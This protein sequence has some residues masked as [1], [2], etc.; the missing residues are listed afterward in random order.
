MARPAP[1]PRAD[2]RRRAARAVQ[3]QARH[4]CIGIP[5][6]SAEARKVQAGQ[7][8]HRAHPGRQRPLRA[9]RANVRIGDASHQGP[10]R[11]CPLN[12][13]AARASGADRRRDAGRRVRAAHERRHRR[14]RRRHPPLL[15]RV[16]ERALAPADPPR[17][18]RLALRDRRLR[19]RAG[20]RQR[21]AVGAEA[22]GARARD[23]R[24]HV[25]Q[26]AGGRRAPALASRSRSQASSAHS[27][28]P[29]SAHC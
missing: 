21:A 16:R 12:G 24:R 19:H 18:R 25:R 13:R 1:A 3:L 26:N 7:G 14:S 20:E 5:G 6:R 23:G 2:Y 28:D 11:D 9:R 29:R 15:A 17:D 27:R 10:L 22:R 4:S 8:C